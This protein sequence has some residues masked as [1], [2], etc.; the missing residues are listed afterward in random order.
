MYSIIIMTNIILKLITACVEKN[1]KDRHYFCTLIFC[2]F[3]RLL[4]IF[5]HLTLVNFQTCN[6]KITS[7]L[8]TTSL[9]STGR[10][11]NVDIWLKID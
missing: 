5:W 4:C 2:D 6:C 7:H 1:L 11:Y 10:C 8:K 9:L 3:G